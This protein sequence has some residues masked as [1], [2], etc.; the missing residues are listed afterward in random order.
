MS[1]IAMSHAVETDSR[2]FGG[3]S[4]PLEILPRAFVVEAPLHFARTAVLTISL[5]SLAGNR[6]Q[7]CDAFEE[8]LFVP[9]L[10]IILTY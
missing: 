6:T 2:S 1:S 7:L 8:D 4:S 10:S 5:A 3:Q 9:F